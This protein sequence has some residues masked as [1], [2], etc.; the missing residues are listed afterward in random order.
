MFPEHDRRQTARARVSPEAVFRRGLRSLV[1]S[2]SAAL[3]SSKPRSF[4]LKPC[5]D[6]RGHGGVDTD[7]GDGVVA[8]SECDVP[9]RRQPA[10]QV[11]AHGQLDEA[12]VAVGRRGE[13]VRAE[14]REVFAGRD[15]PHSADG[16]GRE[17][18]Q[19]A[20]ACRGEDDA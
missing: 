6:H 7:E 14:V 19:R 9:T 16:S 1:T 11:P 12:V 20:I 15:A 17:R 5:P 18:A 4:L 10:F 2:G 13:N 3:L 8:E